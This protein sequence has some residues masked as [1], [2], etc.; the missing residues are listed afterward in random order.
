MTPCVTRGGLASEAPF[1]VELRRRK[2]MVRFHA[3]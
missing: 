2:R 1:L 3:A